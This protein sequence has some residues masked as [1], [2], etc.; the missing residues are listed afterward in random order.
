MGSEMVRC[1][2]AAGLS[3]FGNTFLCLNSEKK[4]QKLLLWEVEVSMPRGLVTVKTDSAQSSNNKY[5]NYLLKI[6][7][8]HGNFWNAIHFF[9]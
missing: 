7:S 8:L 4:K 1:N 6:Y 5:K 3:T 9:K 2:G